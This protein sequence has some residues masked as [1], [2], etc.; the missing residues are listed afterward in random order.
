MADATCKRTDEPCHLE[1]H[2]RSDRR[3][4]D[5]SL[6]AAWE[7]LGGSFRLLLFD[8]ILRKVSSDALKEK[9]LSGGLRSRV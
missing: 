7:D 6:C 9:H 3:A 8:L 4:S 5:K 2:R 1:E